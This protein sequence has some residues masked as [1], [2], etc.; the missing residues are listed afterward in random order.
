MDQP[1]LRSPISLS[2]YWDP[3]QT[4]TGKT[5]REA[6]MRIKP[7][8]TLDEVWREPAPRRTKTQTPW[9]DQLL[10]EI[11]RNNPKLPRA[12]AK[13]MLGQLL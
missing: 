13:A 9:Y 5:R 6:S 1:E 2:N 12:K 8:G 3:P 7:D 4:M 10:E 11:L